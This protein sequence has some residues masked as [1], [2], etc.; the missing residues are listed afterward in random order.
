MAKNKENPADEAEKG[1]TAPLPPGNESNPPEDTP[2]TNTPAE[3]GENPAATGGDTAPLPGNP[4]APAGETVADKPTDANPP[5]QAGLFGSGGTVRARVICAGTFGAVDDVV[6][7]AAE[8]AAQSDELD[9]D[10]VAVA[11]AE[12]LQHGPA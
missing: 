12:S 3:G 11:Y 9:A 5:P 2:A 4:P 7:V 1:A 6:E 10:P 8:L